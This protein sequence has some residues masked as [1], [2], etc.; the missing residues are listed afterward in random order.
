MIRARHWQD[1][2]IAAVSIVILVSPWLAGYQLVQGAMAN[3]VIV[4]AFLFAVAV[5][6]SVIGRPWVE[7]AV[8]ALG[9]WM[10]WSPWVLEFPGE[11]ATLTAV[12]LGGVVLVLGVWALATGARGRGRSVAPGRG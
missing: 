11:R 3:A 5:G 12:A 4:G 1:P 10:V 2:V 9:T 7:C 6:A 8:V